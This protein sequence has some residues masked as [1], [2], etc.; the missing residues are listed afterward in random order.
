MASTRLK[1]LLLLKILIICDAQEQLIHVK[2]DSCPQECF[3]SYQFPDC[4]TLSEYA[5]NTSSYLPSKFILTPG[6]YYLDSHF[7]INGTSFESFSLNGTENTTIYCR[8]N[9]TVSFNGLTSV[10]IQNVAFVS[11]GEGDLP[12]ISLTNINT[13]KMMDISVAN[14]TSGALY[15]KDSSNVEVTN[16]AITNNKNSLATI[17]SIQNS[18]VTSLNNLNIF[19][20]SI[21]V[22]D[23]EC[24][25][26]SFPNVEEVVFRIDG[27][28]LTAES[29][30]VTDNVGLF[31]VMALSNVEAVVNGDWSFKLNRACLGSLFL[32]EVIME[33]TGT[34]LSNENKGISEKDNSNAGLYFSNSQVNING[35][36]ESIANEGYITSIQS[37]GSNI[38]LMEGSSL[39][40]NGNHNGLQAMSLAEG[41]KLVIQNGTLTACNNTMRQR[42]ILVNNSQVI[43][44]G[45][46]T[47]INNSKSP[48]SVHNAII[49]LYGQ[50]YFQDNAG[51]VFAVTSHLDI[52][53]N[54]TFYRNNVDDGFKDGALA[55]FYQS[56]LK[57]WVAIIHFLKIEMKL[58]TVVQYM[59]EPNLLLSLAESEHLKITQ[60]IMEVQFSLRNNLDLNFTMKLIY[61]L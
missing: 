30:D 29:V 54:S 20:N 1:V 43:F 22:Y 38:S 3:C 7:S 14:T 48:F 39:L 46:T 37:L 23:S 55:I 61:T 21:G 34:L 19:R 42:L 36:L 58:W 17:V 2:P 15:I 24:V 16:L 51:V 9:A 27:G 50:I 33:L 40:L 18:I 44:N 26:S 60:Q 4:Q 11:C 53:G 32:S 10:T 8:Q 12:G 13:V 45:H 56:S 5:L 25:Y 57:N 52:D 41:T 59:Q 35:T 31:G 6:L 47:F 49:Q 28:F